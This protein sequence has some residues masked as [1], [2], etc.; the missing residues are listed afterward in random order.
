MQNN[1]SENNFIKSTNA[2]KISYAAF[3]VIFNLRKSFWVQK[4]GKRVRRKSIK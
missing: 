2:L 1:K 3:R 4:R